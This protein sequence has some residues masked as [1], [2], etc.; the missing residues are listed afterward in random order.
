MIR[1]ATSKMSI[2][3]RSISLPVNPCSRRIS[4]IPSRAD[5]EWISALYFLRIVLVTRSRF[6]PDQSISK[7]P[8]IVWHHP[9]FPSNTSRGPVM[10]RIARNAARSASNA[11]FG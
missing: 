11:V 10:P 8:E 9:L 3:I 5:C 7:S 1:C 6:S 4:I 2:R